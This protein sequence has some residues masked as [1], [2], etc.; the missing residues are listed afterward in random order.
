MKLQILIA[1]MHETDFSLLERMNISSDAIVINQTNE[2][3]RFEFS[4]RNK[5]IIWINSTERGLSK[6]RNLALKNC[7]S[8]I[9]LL[10]DNDEIMNDDYETIILDEFL[11]FEN[12]DL[13]VFN[14]EP[15]RP[16][17]KWYFNSKE[18]R[19]RKYNIMKFG[20]PRL[21]FKVEEIKNN[22]IVFNEH[23]GSG[24][25][26]GGGEDS[27]FL[28]DVLKNKLKCFS[29]IK[30]I[31]KIYDDNS[32]W[33]NGYTYDYF[34]KLGAFFDEMYKRNRKIIKFVYLLKHHRL[35]KN[36]GF[37]KAFSALNSK[38]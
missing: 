1:T 36:I 5:D 33:F 28:N 6:S 35:T 14:I 25:S 22:K 9:V 15:I 23:F 31:A 18:K 32:T 24:T 4:Y 3:K 20:S 37:G 30:Y 21:A 11:K 17:N 2:D 38:K 19:L 13:L 10:A 16:K 29:S 34:V 12:V 8:D 27:L 7:S 26:N